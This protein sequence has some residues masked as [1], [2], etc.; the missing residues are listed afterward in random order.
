MNRQLTIGFIGLGNMG[1]VMATNL[2]KDG[3]EVYGLDVSKDAEKKFAESGGK[4]GVSLE[5]IV[6]NLDIIMTSLPSLQAVEDVFLGKDG[7]IQQLE[8]GSRAILIDFST[9]L[10]SLNRKIDDRAKEKGIRFLGIPVSGSV[11]GAQNRTL[12]LMAGGSRSAY[13][14]VEHVLRSLGS[15][16]FYVGE[17]PGAG[18][19]IKL[20]NNYLA[21]SYTQAVSEMLVVADKLGVDKDKLFEIV[22]V[23][24]GR[25]DVYERAYT[26]FISKD[27]YMPG[28]SIQLLYKDLTLFQSMA[29]EK[30]VTL[31]I[32][33]KLIEFYKKALDDGYGAFDV[34][35][36]YLMNKGLSVKDDE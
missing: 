18:S 1:M 27:Q 4:A 11:S 33:S 34:A 8:H 13:E 23:S 22:S 29:K 2:V 19:T 32:G 30:D 36:M 6:R 9:V 31:P 3:Y 25:S 7:I 15:N 14:E 5:Q 16:L 10:P 20:L 26:Q 21:G 28:F 24:S 17:D 35:A 12:A